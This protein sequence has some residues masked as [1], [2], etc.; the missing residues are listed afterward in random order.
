[1]KDFN[2]Y[3]QCTTNKYY[4]KYFHKN[5]ICSCIC[6]SLLGE[7]LGNYTFCSFLSPLLFLC[8]AVVVEFLYYSWFWPLFPLLTIE[9][10]SI[11]NEVTWRAPCFLLFCV[12]Q[13]YSIL[14]LYTMYSLFCWNLFNW[15]NNIFINLNIY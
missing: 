3:L 13:S 7:D 11:S 12:L 10:L 4:Q 15:L 6:F 5:L 2:K 8:S 9:N 1:M 14:E